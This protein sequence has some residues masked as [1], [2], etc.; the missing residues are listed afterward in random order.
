[1]FLK[2]HFSYKKKNILKIELLKISSGTPELIC[3][4][5]P[6]R[7][8]I[9]RREEASVH[10]VRKSPPTGPPENQSRYPEGLLRYTDLRVL[11]LRLLE[12]RRSDLV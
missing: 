4:F 11:L 1:M 6:V 5:T 12:V 10:Y 3:C 2:R 7:L 9:N 8:T